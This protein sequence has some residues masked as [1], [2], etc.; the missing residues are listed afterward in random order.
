MIK[1]AVV[2]SRQWN[3]PT[4]RAYMTVK[5]VGSEMELDEFLKTILEIV[6][7]PTFTMTKNQLANKIFEAKNQILVEMKKAT[8]HV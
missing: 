3:N 4:I 7:S 5:D 6:G 1:E 2:I 8:V